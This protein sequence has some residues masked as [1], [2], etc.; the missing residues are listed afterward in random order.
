MH[1]KES[2]STDVVL[3]IAHDHMTVRHHLTTHYGLS[4]VVA[5]TAVGTELFK[6]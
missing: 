1:E 3:A 6:P 4:A 5:Q 2:I